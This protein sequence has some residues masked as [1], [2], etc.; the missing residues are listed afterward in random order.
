[1]LKQSSGYKGTKIKQG[2]VKEKRG[3]DLKIKDSRGYLMDQMQDAYKI[4]RNQLSPLYSMQL[5][6]GEE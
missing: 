5:K 1:M 2:Y 3:S 4:Q 6:R